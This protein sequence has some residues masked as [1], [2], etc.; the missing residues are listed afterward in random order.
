MKKA[1]VAILLILILAS[2]LTA[3][4]I[5]IGWGGLSIVHHDERVHL[6]TAAAFYRGELNPKE[7]WWGNKSSMIFYP[8]FGMYIVAGAYRLY[9]LA[10]SGL[11]LLPFLTEVRPG[12][13]F[14]PLFELSRKSAL[15]IGRLTVALFGTLTVLVVY[16]A[17]RLIG[18]R[19]VGLL[20][21]AFLA[22]NGYHIA[23]SHWLK[24]DVIAVFFFSFAF[25]YSIRIFFSRRW[26][27]YVLGALFAALAVA[28]KYNCA[29][30]LLALL[31]GHWFQSKREG[32]SL[33]STVLA[34]RLWVALLVFSVCVVAA[35]PVL[36][37]NGPSYPGEFFRYLTRLSGSHLIPKVLQEQTSRPFIISCAVRTRD[38]ARYSTMMEAGM[39]I[40]VTLLGA[41]AIVWS[42]RKR[43]RRG[44]SALFLLAAFTVIYLIF[45]VVLTAAG[46][47]RHQ[48]TIPL[49]PLFSLLAAVFLVRI[50]ERFPFPWSRVFPAVLG[51]LFLIPYGLSAVRMDYG[52]WQKSTK[53][54]G[55]RWCAAN[56]PP[57]SGVALQRKSV[58][59]DSKLYRIFTRRYL[60]VKPVDFYRD[61]GAT[62]FILKGDAHRVRENFPPDHPYHRFYLDLEEEYRL[63]KEFDLGLIPYEW[64]PIK[65]YR[66]PSGSELCP[67]GLNSGLLRHFQ[68]SFSRSSPGLLFLDELGRCE[69]NTNFELP[70]DACSDR[71]LISPAGLGDL[72]VEVTN[73]PEPSTVR[74]KV[75]C[76]KIK[77]RLQPGE[78]KRFVFRPTAGFPFI[79]NSYRVRVSASASPCL[80]RILP[81]AY[82]IGLSYLE[83]GEWEEAV[84]YLEKARNSGDGDWAVDYLLRRAYQQTGEERKAGECTARIEKNFPKLPAMIASLL[85]EKA[86]VEKWNELFYSYSGYGADW[87]EERAGLEEGDSLREWL[88]HY[89]KDW[90]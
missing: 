80:V 37:L 28:S 39:G 75:G 71:L 57:G 76:E 40:Y 55:S 18:G 8:W 67:E 85:D 72:G 73:G 81:N 53:E 43:I 74:V 34:P 14:P 22:L 26:S 20:G 9:G 90:P 68:S 58:Y 84:A 78:V 62:Y 13:V 31:M 1:I 88:E 30:V 45:V 63:V 51:L 27:N 41:A 56:I 4:V 7:I 21:A 23:N 15:L 5:G 60:C 86:G 35:C 59:L 89:W 64:G 19:K 69:G 61:Q 25:L 50:F 17:G 48:E 54:W 11:S 29:P 46:G 44:N 24:N 10:A 65:I 47:V 6:Q 33:V 2:A 82:R 66:E 12:E 32:G 3:R 52:Y 87:L 79:K 42:F 36:Y 16:R 83:A 49:Y 38:L 77:A 70:A